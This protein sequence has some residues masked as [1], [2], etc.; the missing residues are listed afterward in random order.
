MTMTPVRPDQQV[1][2]EP[3]TDAADGAPVRSPGFRLVLLVGLV[4]VAGLT[5]V[6]LLVGPPA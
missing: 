2:D 5:G 1:H 6:A 4:A 3:V